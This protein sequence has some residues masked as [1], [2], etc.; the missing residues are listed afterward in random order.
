MADVR[1]NEVPQSVS[2]HERQQPVSGGGVWGEEGVPIRR[3]TTYVDFAIIKALL[4]VLIDS[5]VCNFRDEGKIRYS[6]LLL[7][8]RFEHR[9]AHLLVLLVGSSCC[10]EVG[11]AASVLF[12]PGTFRY[13][14]FHVGG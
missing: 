12:A 6:D 11:F 5:L 14:L 13:T 1:L 2:S 9:L 8:C 10:C 4:Q 7:F 3:G